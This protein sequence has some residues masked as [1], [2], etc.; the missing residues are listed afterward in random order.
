M[1]GP[2]RFFDPL[3]GPVNL[4]EFEAEL[5]ST[6]EFQRLRSVRMCNINSMLISGASEISRF[7][8]SVGVLRLAQVWGR[9]HGLT[10]DDFDILR[11]A[12]LLHDMQTGPFGHSLQYVVEDNQLQNNFVHDDI[13]HGYQEQFHQ[14][15]LATAGY[16]GSVFSSP[17]IL[18]R[19]WDRVAE[20]I[21]GGGKFGPLISG[22]LDLDNLDNVF[23]LAYHVGVATTDDSRTIEPFVESLEIVDGELSIPRGQIKFVARWHEV[24]K[25]LYELLLLDWAEFSAK[26]MLTLAIEKA[27]DGGLLDQ[28]SWL[29]TDAQLLDVLEARGVGE[30]Q[31]VGELVR[32]LRLGDLYVPIFLGRTDD[33]ELYESLNATEAKRALEQQLMKKIRAKG[34]APGK[35]LVHLILDRKKT[36]RAVSVRVQGQGLVDVGTDS[37]QLLIGIFSSVDHPVAARDAIAEEFRAAISAMSFG[38]LRPLEDPVL[39]ELRSDD[40][41]LDLGWAT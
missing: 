29:L 38:T 11:A 6:A 9:A 40:K 28:Q 25:R 15:L 34:R 36:C 24:R 7:E 10:G 32:R 33:V 5:V 18:S 8:H 12:A 31:S 37:R 35:L 16:R 21:R 22:S 27:F 19:L 4:D 26:A 30:L 2:T 41:Q 20:A 1:K 13:L 14:R 17:R 39:G 3:Y 23:R